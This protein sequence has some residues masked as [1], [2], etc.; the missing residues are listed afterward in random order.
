MPS[1]AEST[2]IINTLLFSMTTSSMKAM[3]ASSYPTSSTSFALATDR[4][5]SC[6]NPLVLCAAAKA[7]DLVL[8]AD[9]FKVVAGELVALISANGSVSVSV[10][11]VN[12]G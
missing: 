4:P 6:L 7:E 3:S 5:V 12:S 10:V 9:R 8:F 1:H 2:H 11:V